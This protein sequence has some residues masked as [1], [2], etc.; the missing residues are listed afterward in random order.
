MTFK[1][2][3][4]TTWHIEAEKIW[5]VA[6]PSRKKGKQLVPQTKQSQSTTEDEMHED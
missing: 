1:P 6:E 5:V 2:P 3:N 4:S